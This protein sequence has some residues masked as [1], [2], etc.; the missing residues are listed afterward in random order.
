MAQIFNKHC[1]ISQQSHLPMFSETKIV[2]SNKTILY[3]ILMMFSFHLLH[4]YYPDSDVFCVFW[5]SSLR[6]ASPTWP[7][8]QSTCLTPR[9]ACRLWSQSFSLCAFKDLHRSVPAFSLT[10]QLRLVR[11]IVTQGVL[12]QNTVLFL[13]R[14]AELLPVRTNLGY[15]QNI[16][17]LPVAVSASTRCP[18]CLLPSLLPSRRQI[19]HPLYLP[20]S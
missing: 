6:V 10:S 16:N 13:V 11:M 2:L 19:R 15:C 17:L 20:S 8:P 18:W 5:N 4:A 14:M 9:D 12:H 7:V 1:C 3:S